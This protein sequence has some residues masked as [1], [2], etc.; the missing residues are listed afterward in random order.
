MLKVLSMLPFAGILLFSAPSQAEPVK[1]EPSSA[2]ACL[3]A[4]VITRS[5][6]DRVTQIENTCL[7]SIR[8]FWCQSGG[9]DPKYACGANGKFFQH[10]T[11]LA[12][13]RQYS[14][15]YNLPA[16][17]VLRFAV[18]WGSRG[19]DI[20]DGNVECKTPRVEDVKTSGKITC[21]DKEVE[22]HVSEPKPGIMVYKST[23]GSRY[24]YNTRKNGEA[25]DLD[26]EEV[27]RTICNEKK[28]DVG[29]AGKIIIRAR[30]ELRK[31]AEEQAKKALEE[32]IA[33]Y[34]KEEC[35]PYRRPGIGGKAG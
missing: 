12:P 6:G 1:A 5:S 30:G 19:K 2:A 32:C 10:G 31:A 24:V 8:A 7:Y 23:G 17:K 18:C 33:R 3:S 26:S 22:F 9:A 25:Q 29:V 34:G 4:E 13:G 14:N 21:K 27:R 11:T 35:K 20:G 28:S 15:Y 16:D